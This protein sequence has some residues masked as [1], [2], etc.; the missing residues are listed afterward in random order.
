[1]GTGAV[2]PLPEDGASLPGGTQ[3][4][5]VRCPRPGSLGKAA[6]SRLAPGAANPGRRLGSHSGPGPSRAGRPHLLTPAASVRELQGDRVPPRL[7]GHRL[8]HCPPSSF[9]LRSRGSEAMFGKE[10]DD[11]GDKN[12][13]FTECSLFKTSGRVVL[14]FLNRPESRLENAQSSVSPSGGVRLLPTRLQTA[15]APSSALLLP[16]PGPRSLFTKSG[17]TATAQLC[18]RCSIRE[19]PRLGFYGR[20][21]SSL[22]EFQS[23][24]Y[25]IM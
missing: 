3:A 7:A 10:C 2:P 5:G 1:M 13:I 25:V 19:C 24:N 21:V 15:R 4:G 12:I 9:V 14:L 8:T 18:L 23:R 22:F 6:P 16:S 11:R 20:S 17:R